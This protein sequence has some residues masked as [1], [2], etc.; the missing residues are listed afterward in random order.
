M[1]AGLV[2]LVFVAAVA[3]FATATQAGGL[4]VPAKVIY[5]DWR[6]I[7]WNAPQNTVTQAVDGGYNV[8]IIAFYLLNG[9]TDMAQ[10]WASVSKGNQQQAM[11]YAHSKGAKVMV[12]AGGSTE[13]PYGQVSGYGYGQRVAQW[14]VDNNLDGVDFDMENLR[15]GFIAPG[16]S[17]AA[18]TVQWLADASNGARSVLGNNR[19]ISHAPQAPY[20]GR[21]GGGGGN[22]WPGSSGGYTAV[23]QKATT[24]D[25]FNC[26]FYNQGASCY[27]SYQGLFVDSSSCSAFPGTAL[28]QIAAYGVPKEKIVVGKPVTTAD[29][30]S[31][32][33]DPNTLAGF[34]R[35]ARNTG[36][37]AGVMGWEWAGTQT[38]QWIHTLYP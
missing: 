7:N 37:N 33:V 27:T 35:Q 26:Q 30:G 28:Q 31:G 8:V 38:G 22:S 6:A 14:A 34:L 4:P 16:L 3:I 9:P 25:F 5:I 2:A 23:Y 15:P 21:V 17:S 18:A 32:Y 12:S 20:F 19:L 24:I 1:R 29:G 11:N 10:A 13:S 36:W